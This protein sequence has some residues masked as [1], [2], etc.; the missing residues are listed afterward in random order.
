MVCDTHPGGNLAAEA[1]GAGTT[2]VAGRSGLTVLLIQVLFK[3]KPVTYL[4]QPVIEDESSEVCIDSYN[5]RR[6]RILS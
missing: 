2:R 6:E 1:T 4:P 5:P 3:R